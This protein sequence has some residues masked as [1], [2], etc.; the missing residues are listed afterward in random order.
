MDDHTV[1]DQKG[2]FPSL[3]TERLLLRAFVLE[4]A[5]RVRLL[6]G[7]KE[8]AS[9]TLAIPHPYEEGMAEAWIGTHQEGFDKGNLITFAIVLRSSDELIGAI[10]LTVNQEHA[11]AELGYWIGKPYWNHG[12][13]TEAAEE[14]LRYGFEQLDLNRIYATH[15][16]RNPA[17]GRVMK[18]LGMM[19]EG[20]R[21]KHVLKWGV[22]EDLEM[23]GIL[24]SE[25]TSLKA[26][27]RS[28]PQ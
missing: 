24:K 11:N 5:P 3:K 20:C 28:N 17:S 25:F 9:N 13:C 23:Y 26:R 15:L 1:G 21:R 16:R 14:V 19:H 7:E 6:A 18:K 27:R 10:G 8:I 22:F 4:D 2:E 12:Y